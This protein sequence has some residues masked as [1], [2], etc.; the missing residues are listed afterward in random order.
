MR[1]KATNRFSIRC[2][3]VRV[4]ASRISA[5][6]EDKR[7]KAPSIVTSVGLSRSRRASSLR[8]STMSDTPLITRSSSSTESRIVRGAAILPWASATVAATGVAVS[9]PGASAWISAL[10]SPPGIRTGFDRRDHLPNPIDDREHRA[11]QRAIGV[12]T[13][14]ADIG[15]C[16]FARVAEGFEPGKIE[17]AAIAFDGVDEAEDRIEPRAI[18]RLGLPRD[19]FAAESLEHFPAFGHEIRNQ[20]SIAA[21][22]P[23]P[24]FEPLMGARS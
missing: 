3:R 19:D 5:M 13:A 11:D 2:M 23:Q 8:A 24:L 10:S 21:K 14:G 15:E 17:E 20:S 22:G 16:I 1:G 7:S 9:V 12:A 6:I 18:I 4:M